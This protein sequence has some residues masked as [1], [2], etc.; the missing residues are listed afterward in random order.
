M[1]LCQGDVYGGHYYAYIR[2]SIGDFWGNVSEVNRDVDAAINSESGLRSD[3]GRGGEWFKFDDDFVSKVDRR[4]AVEGSYGSA[5]A[6]FLR[7]SYH[8]A[9]M[10]VYIRESDACRT[11]A[12]VAIPDALT[13][14]LNKEYLRNIEAER[15]LEIQSLFTEVRY[16]IKDDLTDFASYTRH[17]DFFIPEESRKLKIMKKTML[18]GYLMAFSEILDV[19]VDR[20]RLW[21]IGRADDHDVWRIDDKLDLRRCGFDPLVGYGGKK[22]IFYVE[23]LPNTVDLN[24]VDCLDTLK[25]FERTWLESCRSAIDDVVGDT[26]YD[27]T[28]GCGVCKGNLPIL[29]YL[30]DGSI[31]MKLLIDYNEQ[32]DFFHRILLKSK[33]YVENDD[34]NFMLIVKYLNINFAGEIQEP[35]VMKNVWVQGVNDSHTTYNDIKRIAMAAVT[36]EIVRNVENGDWSE[37]ESIAFQNIWRRGELIKVMS[38]TD[39]DRCP[40]SVGHVPLSH[41]DALQC[42][43]I[44]CLVPVPYLGNGDD[45]TDDIASNDDEISP[46]VSELISYLRSIVL[47]QDMNVKPR[48]R[49]HVPHYDILNRRTGLWCCARSLFSLGDAEIDGFDELNEAIPEGGV[50]VSVNEDFNSH[51]MLNAVDGAIMY[52]DPSRLRIGTIIE[53]GYRVSKYVA[54]QDDF[55]KRS[56]HLTE[57]ILVEALPFPSKLVDQEISSCKY[58]EVFLIGANLKS[59]RQEWLDNVMLPCARDLYKKQILA[60]V[61]NVFHL[62]RVFDYLPWTEGVDRIPDEYL[63]AGK[64]YFTI[65]MPSDQSEKFS[66]T[67]HDLVQQFRKN[68]G[69]S[70]SS[71]DRIPGPSSSGMFGKKRSAEGAGLHAGGRDAVDKDTESLTLAKNDSTPEGVSTTENQVNT[72]K[73]K[74]THLLKYAE[75]VHAEDGDIDRIMMYNVRNGKIFKF[76]CAETEVSCLPKSWYDICTASCD[77]MLIIILV[78]ECVISLCFLFYFCS[79]Q[80]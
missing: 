21:H 72:V 6:T 70:L 73:S 10:L 50:S 68:M 67:V 33:S 57:D 30:P 52:G 32:N 35:V 61:N 55:F 20:I 48:Q 7:R 58:Y 69:L 25:K 16:V 66:F 36:N 38:P 43:D 11:M 22:H 39:L 40:R 26:G 5:G 76:L 19:R 9:Y 56:D 46:Y 78:G 65:D 80:G 74:L 4:E 42:G 71:S 54:V 75:Y 15:Q 49:I 64:C 34:V 60:G 45:S 3:L 12:D 23:V 17:C 13:T 41:Q 59:I 1:L 8:S 18:G 31:K 47:T 24:F 14:R 28:A 77:I 62:K 79:Y 37:D 44:V 63:S 51:E 29:K 2:P 27:R 53:Q